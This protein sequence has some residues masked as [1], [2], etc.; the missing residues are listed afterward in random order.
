M[1]V[2]VSGKSNLGQESKR[3]PNMSTTNSTVGKWQRGGWLRMITRKQKNQWEVSKRC[4]TKSRWRYLLCFSFTIS[5]NNPKNLQL[6]LMP[7]EKKDAKIYVKNWPKNFE[8]T[9]SAQCCRGVFLRHSN[10]GFSTI[11]FGFF[12]QKKIWDYCLFKIYQSRND[13]MDA[14]RPSVRERT[15]LR[16][17]VLAI[18]HLISFFYTFNSTLFSWNC[19]EIWW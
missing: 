1:P 15:C 7:P 6:F 9:S 3:I 8:W 5:R 4:A 16:A 12:L 11:D 10:F 17:L 18:W 14:I 2:C 19:K 13:L